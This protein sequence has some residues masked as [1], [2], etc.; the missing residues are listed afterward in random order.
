[1]SKPRKHQGRPGR[2][3]HA[4]VA[5]K[6]VVASLLE[7]MK[8][9][10]E[11][12]SIVGLDTNV[13]IVAELRRGLAEIEAARGRPCIC[14][15]ANVIKPVR[16]TSISASD[17]LPFCEMVG[18]VP[19]GTDAVDV[20][21]VTPGG[22][23]EQVTAFVD[24]LR[25]RFKSVEFLLPYQ[26]MSAGTLWVLSGDKIWMD[27]RA[28]LGPIDPQVPSKD[29][30]YVPAQALLSLVAAFQAQGQAAMAQG[31][32]PDWTQILILKELDYRQLGAAHTASQYSITM[33]AEFLVKY[34]FRA[35][36]THA[37]S[38]QPV[39]S[40]DRMARAVE[41]AGLLGSH[42]RWKAHGHAL[43]R[44]TV[45]GELRIKIDNPDH[46]LQRAIRRVWA[47]FYFVLDRT[48]TSKIMLSR[49]YSFVRTDP[50]QQV[51]P[52]RHV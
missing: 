24:A 40:H 14:Y 28:C 15:V 45:E 35:W 39:T 30:R 7:H 12:G 26:A 19:A 48:P 21:L 9:G 6:R 18:G 31:R 52:S 3:T 44:A 37:S 17:H 47:L 32:S 22:S 49:G 16:E 2:N 34:K 50:S 43:N 1:M 38:G 51:T 42:D 36:T 29:G 4:E 46:V 20:L 5:G 33:A 11:Y 10:N 41:V 13:D 25:S 8:D 23:G 27:E